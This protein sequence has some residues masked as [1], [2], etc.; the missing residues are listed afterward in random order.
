LLDVAGLGAFAAADADAQVQGITELHAR[1]RL[2]ILNADIDG[3]L[4]FGFALKAVQNDLHVDRRKL[5]VVSLQK[6]FDGNIARP[7]SQRRDGLGERRR[8]QHRPHAF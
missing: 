3:V 5:P 4:L 8:A 1:L 2:V 6:I 7:L